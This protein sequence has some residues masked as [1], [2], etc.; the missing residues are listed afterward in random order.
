MC[1]VRVHRIREIISMK[2]LKITIYENFDPQNFSA[3]WYTNCAN[4]SQIARLSTNQMQIS[5]FAWLS[6]ATSEIRIRL[7][8]N[9]STADAWIDVATVL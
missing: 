1:G 6:R 7:V 3:I 5:L 9:S 8:N 4:L 2:S